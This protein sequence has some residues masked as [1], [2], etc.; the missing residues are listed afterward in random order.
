MNLIKTEAAEPLCGLWILVPTVT[1][2]NA[3]AIGQ[4]VVV[5]LF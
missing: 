1:A 4:S 3:L 2:K 5:F